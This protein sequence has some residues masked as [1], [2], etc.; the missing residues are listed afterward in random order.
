MWE[1]KMLMNLWQAEAIS[2]AW[3]MSR[4]WDR[5][6]IANVCQL[7]YV[8]E[9]SYSISHLC[10]E[11]ATGVIKLRKWWEIIFV[12]TNFLCFDPQYE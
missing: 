4:T 10:D 5:G 2:A 7:Y 11:N 1:R 8:C 6:N 3:P 9:V 12:I